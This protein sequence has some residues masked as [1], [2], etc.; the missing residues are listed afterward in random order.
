MDKIVADGQSRPKSPLGGGRFARFQPLVDL[1]PS[2]AL[3]EAV[4][5]ERLGGPYSD[6]LAAVLSTLA[7]LLSTPDSMKFGVYFCISALACLL[8]AADIPDLWGKALF[9]YL[10]FSMGLL[11]AAYF[12]DRPGWMFKRPDGRIRLVGYLLFLPY[13]FFNHL[14]WRMVV[15]LSREPPYHEIVP[16]LFLGRRLHRGEAHRFESLGMAAVLDL[17]CEFAEPSFLTQVDSP[18][19]PILDATAPRLDQL[20]QGIDWLADRHTQGPVYVHCAAGH[21]RSATFVAGYLLKSQAAQD[22]ADAV[23]EVAQRRPRIRLVPA[24][25]RVLEAYQAAGGA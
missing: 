18:C 9:G 10:G 17:T 11:S 2:A 22:A 24:Q 12:A 6:S 8:I 1:P 13:Q 5:G 14:A 4:A 23:A 7:L 16:G 20:E 19:L 3:R 15:A 21:G 25:L